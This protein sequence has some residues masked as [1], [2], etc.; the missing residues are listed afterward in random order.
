MNANNPENAMTSPAFFQETAM[1][2]A[3]PKPI[4]QMQKYK[5]FATHPLT[6]LCGGCG[7]CGSLED[8]RSAVYVVS[9][10]LLPSKPVS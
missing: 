5:V 7:V 1:K 6:V 2:D 4:T 10:H 8:D 9:G 3:I